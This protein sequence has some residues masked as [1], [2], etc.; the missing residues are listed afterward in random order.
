MQAL[1]TYPKSA[2][3]RVWQGELTV[4]G[5]QELQRRK[6]IKNTGPPYW[7]V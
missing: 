6:Q 2:N 4:G 5:G 3:P 1:V 7:P